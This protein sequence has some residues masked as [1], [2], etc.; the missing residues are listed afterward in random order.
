MA[1][2]EFTIDKQEYSSVFRLFDRENSG[3][4]SIQ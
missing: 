2:N 4:I 1:S 3:K